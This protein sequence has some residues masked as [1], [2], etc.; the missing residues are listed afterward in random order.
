MIG[1]GK[2]D[3]VCTLARQLAGAKGCIVIIRDGKNGDG[4]SAQLS[5]GDLQALPSVLRS[6]AGQIERDESDVPRGVNLD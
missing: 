2:Y 6:I 3:D 1:P 4:F 5:L